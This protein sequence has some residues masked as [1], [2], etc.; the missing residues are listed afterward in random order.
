MT[1][2]GLL[3]NNTIITSAIGGGHVFVTNLSLATFETWGRR[4]VGLASEEV[5]V[6]WSTDHL[7]VTAAATTE[8]QLLSCSAG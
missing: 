2:K 6:S 5:V 3:I 1:N 4:A 7:I 8:Q